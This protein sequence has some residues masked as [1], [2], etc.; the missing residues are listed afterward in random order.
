[1]ELIRCFDFEKK[2]ILEAKM[3]FWI[4]SNAAS[5]DWDSI[6]VVHYCCLEN[7]RSVLLY[8]KRES[9]VFKFL[10]ATNERTHIRKY[11]VITIENGQ[12]R[13]YYTNPFAQ[14][15]DIDWSRLVAEFIT[16]V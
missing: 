4:Y 9:Y 15:L 8:C 13:S 2:L 16:R 7:G 5:K 14:C 6:C 11:F 1:M 10:D 12:N 3:N